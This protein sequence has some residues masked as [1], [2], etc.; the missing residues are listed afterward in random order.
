MSLLGQALTRS[1]QGAQQ[2][3]GELTC[4]PV[5][6][7]GLAPALAGVKRNFSGTF[8]GSPYS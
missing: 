3:P 8:T 6:S 7:P 1:D 2:T 4:S 5:H